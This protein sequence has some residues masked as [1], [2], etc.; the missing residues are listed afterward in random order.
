VELRLIYS[1][2]PLYAFDHGIYALFHIIAYFGAQV[3]EC[4]PQTSQIQV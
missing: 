2:H 3:V 4:H 1:I